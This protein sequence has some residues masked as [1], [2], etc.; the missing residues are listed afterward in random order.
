VSTNGSQ[1]LIP[2]RFESRENIATTLATTFGRFGS[3]RDPLKY[4]EF[5]QIENWC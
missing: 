4:S 1:P 5:A 3:S 2:Q